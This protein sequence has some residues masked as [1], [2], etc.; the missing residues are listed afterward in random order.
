MIRF[1]IISMIAGILPNL[2]FSQDISQEHGNVYLK[3]FKE[4][5]NFKSK[6][7]DGI[8]EEERRGWKQYKRWEYFWEQRTYPNGE[9]PEGIEIFKDFQKFRKKAPKN[10][11]LQSNL[12]ELVGPIN[13]PHSENTRQQGIGRLNIIRF[14]PFDPNEI[15]AG[16]ASGGLWKSENRGASW[17]KFPFTEFLS[18][19]ISDVA[20]S[21]QNEGTV[22]VATGDLDH[23]DAYSIGIIK[24][25]NGGQS[26]QVTDFSY[27]LSSRIIVGRLLIHPEDDQNV[28]AATN[29]GIFKTTDGGNNWVQ[30]LDG[31]GLIDMEFKPGDENIVYA[32]TKSWSG[33]N[34][35]YKSTDNG[36]NWTK[37]YENNG[38]LRI[39][40]NVSE[41]APKRVYAVVAA[42]GNRSLHSFMISED[43]GETW[44]VIHT[45]KEGKNILGRYRG[46]LADSSGQGEYDLCLAI[47]PTNADEIYVG[48]INI[49]KSIDGGDSWNLVTHWQGYYQKPLVHADIHDLIFGPD[50]TL[51]AAHDGG[52]D[53]TKNKGIDWDYLSDGQSITQ[54]YRLSTSETLDG[55]VIAGSQDNG[56]SYIKN[57]YWTHCLASDGMDNAIDPKNAQRVYASMYNG[58]FY[59]STD[60][61]E[62]FDFMI[63]PSQKGETGA[64]VTPIL[65]DP[66]NPR[67]IYIGYENVWKSTDYGVHW[68]K[69]SDFGRSNVTIRSLAISPTNNAIVYAATYGT[70]Y[71]SVDYG[72]SWNHYYDSKNAISYMV[73]DPTDPHRLF[74]SNSGY[75]KHEKVMAIYNG[76]ETNLTGNLPNVPVNC[77]VYQKDSPQRLYIG[78]DIGVF[79]SDYGSAYWQIYGDDLP[80]VVISDLDINYKTRQLYAATFGR[81]I[82]RADLIEDDA[83]ELEIT[84]EG[85][86]EFC[87][88]DS[89]VLKSTKELPAYYWS[90]GETTR[91]IVVKESADI[92]LIQAPVT[93]GS[94]KS[95]N[96]SVI[97][98]N[99][100]E[101]KVTMRGD[102][103]FCEGD[104][105]DLIGFLG[106]VDYN[107]SNGENN[108]KITI[109]EPGEYFVVGI[110]PNGCEST[111]EIIKLEM[112]PA[113]DVPM[114]TRNKNVLSTP[115]VDET[116]S[117]QWYYENEPID[118]ANENEL[119][120]SDLGIYHVEVISENGCSTFSEEYDAITSVE[121][122][123]H[124]SFLTVYP[125]P[126]A[127]KFNI[128]YYNSSQ[129]IITFEITNLLGKIIYTQT[130]RID[131]KYSNEIDLS[132]FGAGVYFIKA[133]SNNKIHTQKLIIK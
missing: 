30:K 4:I 88:G 2:L 13:R 25:T 39:A 85:E 107:W 77:I 70:I 34:F 106:F 19:G 59:R 115:I 16:S 14:N 7:W 61:G 54:F 82:W 87:L 72:K 120:F 53:I 35:I 36:E 5:K 121:E 42:A 95:K 98:N 52:L 124:N 101:M 127:G 28:I 50:G 75:D 131:G 79:Y 8:P 49:W 55:F 60:G 9:F 89:V 109:T 114:I 26:W 123:S 125:N 15:W 23:N 128:N 58:K 33:T 130:V 94:A 40:I 22:Y 48:G 65:V 6:L 62:D 71:K 133:I 99:V 41:K 57:G 110:A 63:K 32:S 129:E 112:I 91:S 122:K 20:F 104:E 45:P 119:V 100:N 108:R 21:R 68:D 81:G 66:L 116:Y 93:Y 29:I 97:M 37:T 38:I 76:V 113:P 31:Y 96:I 11:K 73:V 56:T 43:E 12:W 44:N 92:C 111:S 80:N 27:D 17:T 74:I 126:T 10:D 78:T 132:K 103:P 105:V 3:N 90:T 102:N 51:Y 64:W 46:N 18:L 24:S 47:S 69:V 117:Y 84:I 1:L 67:N 83:S 86:T 118:G